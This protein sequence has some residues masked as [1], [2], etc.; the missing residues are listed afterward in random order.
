MKITKRFKWEMA[1]RLSF[2]KGKCY[3]LHGHS[4]SMK[5]S[6]EGRLDKHGFVMDFGDLKNIFNE[7]VEKN[8]DH[9]IMLYKNDPILPFLK[10]AE[11]E[12]LEKEHRSLNIVTVPFEPTSENISKYLFEKFNK[13]VMKETLG[14]CKVNR[15]K[16]YETESSEAVYYG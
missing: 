12:R 3:Y 1:H 10:Q 14:R 6:V 5:V 8:L 13:E 4:W 11:N 16:V 2:H 15:V 9:S 7:I